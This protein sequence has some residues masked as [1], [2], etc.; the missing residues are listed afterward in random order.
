MALDADLRRA[1]SKAAIKAGIGLCV[2][3]A[4]L[5]IRIVTADRDGVEGEIAELE[6]FEAQRAS[7]LEPTPANGAAGRAPASDTLAAAPAAPPTATAGAAAAPSKRRRS[8]ATGEERLVACDLGGGRQFTRAA[9]C[10]ARGGR[11]VELD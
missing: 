2:V 7:E 8:S 11:L 4:V 9:D 10:A 6:A 5:G 1:C 3:A